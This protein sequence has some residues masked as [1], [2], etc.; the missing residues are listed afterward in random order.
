[1][2]AVSTDEITNYVVDNQ[3]LKDINLDIGRKGYKY[4]VNAF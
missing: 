2:E 1:M 3:N 4:M